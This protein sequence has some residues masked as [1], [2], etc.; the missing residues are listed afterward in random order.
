MTP[1]GYFS[2]PK[3]FSIRFLVQNRSNL[4]S[5]MKIA[6]AGI[7]TLLSGL[8][9]SDPDPEFLA[10]ESSDPDPELLALE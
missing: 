7:F 1:K 2:D 6:R 5:F 4:Q 3:T 10:S 9:L 8:V